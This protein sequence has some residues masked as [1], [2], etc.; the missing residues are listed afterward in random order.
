[1]TKRFVFPWEI[2]A[3]AAIDAA[4]QSL[5]E[6][7]EA[8]ADIR[9]C[10]LYVPTKM[11]LKH[12]TLSTR[13]GND[14]AAELY[15]GNPLRFGPATLRATT[16]LTFKAYARADAI[17]VIY[18]DQGMMD[19]VD[20]NKSLRLVICAP[21]A[22]GA[23]EGWINSWKPTMPAGGHRG[24]RGLT[25]PVVEAALRGLTLRINRNNGVLG[26]SDKASVK[27]VFLILRAKGHTEDPEAVRACC[28]GHEWLPGAANEA[29]VLAG[30]AFD[31]A[32]KPSLASIENADARYEQWVKASASRG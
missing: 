9:E 6:C 3:D 27:E 5:K 8:D 17:L 28:I 32:T 19:K 7:I 21:H 11:Q 14:D 13:L 2:G 1:M 31:R 22:S 16:H 12:S 10:L 4:L 15:K 26:A 30:R 23:V 20:T 29:M 18:A 25:D 24:S